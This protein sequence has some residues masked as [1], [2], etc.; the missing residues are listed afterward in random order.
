MI[1][2]D[3]RM[4]LYKKLEIYFREFNY[5]VLDLNFKLR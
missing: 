4:Y 2:V 5:I 3:I 1:E